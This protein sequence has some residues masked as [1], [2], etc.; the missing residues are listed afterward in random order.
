MDAR[1]ELA[2]LTLGKIVSGLLLLTGLLI[3]IIW[4][5]TLASKWAQVAEGLSKPALMALLG[6]VLIAAILEALV[7]L[8]FSYFLFSKWLFPN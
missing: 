8:L 7:I 4:R 5:E 2:K 6:L 3:A 1:E